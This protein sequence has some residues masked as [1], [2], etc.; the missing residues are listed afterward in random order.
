MEVENTPSGGELNDLLKELMNGILE[1]DNENPKLQVEE[2]DTG[3]F[4][5][6]AEA[7]ELIRAPVAKGDVRANTG[8]LVEMK[9]REVEGLLNRVLIRLHI[10][11][12]REV[13]IRNRGVHEA[14]ILKSDT[15]DVKL[16]EE[17]ERLLE[18]KS[19]IMS[20]AVKVALERIISS[21][22]HL[23]AY[24]RAILLKKRYLKYPRSKSRMQPLSHISYHSVK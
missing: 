7:T 19:S 22:S 17:R 4:V 9:V 8:M 3:I 1:E 12:R 18:E 23:A 21:I 6:P 14:E 13:E 11:D 24:R 5:S 15:V 10:N 2:V 16:K 20:R